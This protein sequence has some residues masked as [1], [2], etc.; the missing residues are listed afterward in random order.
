MQPTTS[1]LRTNPWRLLTNVKDK[2]EPEDRPGA[3]YKIKCSN[4][5]ATYVGK[6]GRDF[7]TWLNEHKQAAKK[8]DLNN[9]IAEHRL[10][11]SHTIDWGSATL[12]V[13]LTT[14]NELHSK[15]CL[16]T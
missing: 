6:T 9:N 10:K 2:D 5:Q 7:M 13:V 15:A 3:V 14:I 8:G 16:L 12:P 1:K 4:C 11:T